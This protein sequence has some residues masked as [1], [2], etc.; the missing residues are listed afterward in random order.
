AGGVIG[1]GREVEQHPGL[2]M[3][4]AV[5]PGVEVNAFHIDTSALPERDDASSAWQR[6]VGVAA[7]KDPH[8]ILLPDPFTCDAENLLRALDRTYPRSQ[9]VGGLAS[10]G[11][12]PGENAL[13]L[14]SDLHRSGLAGVAL[15]GNIRLDTVV[16]QGCRPIGQPMFITKCQEN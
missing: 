12:E 9:K 13:F 3:T 15:A 6:L 10:G 14:G 1:G 2:S 5:L 7:D 11:R 8:F 16:A 4:A